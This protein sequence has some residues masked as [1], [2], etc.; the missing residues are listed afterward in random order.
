MSPVNE[1]GFLLHTNF[2]ESKY[3]NVLFQVGVDILG[4]RDSFPDC[5]FRFSTKLAIHNNIEF[6][7]RRLQV[8]MPEKSSRQK[9]CG[10]HLFTSDR[11]PAGSIRSGCRTHQHDTF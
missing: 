4:V 7:L 2:V 9:I 8:T 10:L 1:N 5:T 11:A 3:L 6:D